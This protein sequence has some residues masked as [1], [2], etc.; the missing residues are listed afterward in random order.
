MLK[1]TIVVMSVI[2]LLFANS[3]VFA[4]EYIEEELNEEEFGGVVQETLAEAPKVPTINSRHAIIYD[5]ATR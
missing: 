5:R 4:E 3:I 1:K 2:L